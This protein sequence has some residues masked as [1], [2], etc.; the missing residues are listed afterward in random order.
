MNSHKQ[1]HIPC[2]CG[3]STDAYCVNEKG[4][5]KCFSCGKKFPPKDEGENNIIPQTATTPEPVRKEFKPHPEEFKPFRGYSAASSRKFLIDVYTEDE[6]DVLARYPIFSNGHHIGNKVRC[7]DK[8]FYVEGDTKNKPLDLG[9]QH[10][11][12]AGCAKTV[13]VVEGQDD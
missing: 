1:V 10:A 9:G 6:S 11:F 8:K 5:G 3:Q 7:K 13:T 2:P 12:P 4:W